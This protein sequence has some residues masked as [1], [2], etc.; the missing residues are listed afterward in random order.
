[1][2]EP[3]GCFLALN[4]VFLIEFLQVVDKI[5]LVVDKL[6]QVVD[7]PPPVVDKNSRQ[8]ITSVNSHN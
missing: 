3:V 5:P 8:V 7:N 6:T 1:M 4:D 2:G